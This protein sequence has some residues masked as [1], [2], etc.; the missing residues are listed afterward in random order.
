LDY[1]VLRRCDDFVADHS[2]CVE[3]DMV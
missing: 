2:A 3:L 1:G